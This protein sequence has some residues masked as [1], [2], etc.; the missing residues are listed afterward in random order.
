MV[1]FVVL[2]LVKKIWFI[3]TAAIKIMAFE[4]RG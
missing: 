4:G 3:G 1:T 2:K